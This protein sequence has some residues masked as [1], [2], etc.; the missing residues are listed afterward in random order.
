MVFNQTDRFFLHESPKGKNR[1][2]ILAE[3]YVRKLALLQTRRLQFNL[4]IS[5]NIFE[6]PMRRLAVN[7]PVLPTSRCSLIFRT[8]VT[9]K[10]F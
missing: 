1:S 5:G 2:T 3:C 8:K 6:A 7:R 10:L 4:N 9:E